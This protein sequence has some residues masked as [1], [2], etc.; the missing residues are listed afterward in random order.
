MGV[1]Y[2]GQRQVKQHPSDCQ[3]SHFHIT[4]IGLQIDTHTRTHTHTHTHARK[5]THARAHAHTRTHAPVGLCAGVRREHVFQTVHRDAKGL[6]QTQ[7]QTHTHT[8][9]HTHNVSFYQTTLMFLCH[10]VFLW[11]PALVVV[12]SHLCQFHFFS[13]VYLSNRH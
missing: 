5:R 10:I 3:H 13:L 6:T 1:L 2:C 9:T 7:T 4:L 8:H 12:Y 11:D